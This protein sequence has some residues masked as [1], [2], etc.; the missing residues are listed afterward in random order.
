MYSLPGV[1]QTV[2]TALKLLEVE[3]QLGVTSEKPCSEVVKHV[4]WQRLAVCFV[5]LLGRMADNYHLERAAFEQ[6]LKESQEGS[7]AHGQIRASGA[8]SNDPASPE[9]DQ[10][11]K[12]RRTGLLSHPPNLQIAPLPSDHSECSSKSMLRDASARLFAHVALL[13][14][15]C[16]VANHL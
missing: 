10:Q 1:Q 16:R 9:S 15:C 2:T 12:R 7:A 5:L 13:I 14:H 4:R 8:P 11:S 6:R 3:V